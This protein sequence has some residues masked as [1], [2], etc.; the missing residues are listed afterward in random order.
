MT[1]DTIV[2]LE[3]KQGQT[4]VLFEDMQRKVIS[5]GVNEFLDKLCLGHGGTVKGNQK[6]MSVSLN[7]RQKIP[8]LICRKKRFI[9]YPVTQVSG[10][11]VWIRYLYSQKIKK[12]H[13]YKTR[14]I[15]HEQMG[16]DVDA[17][18]RAVQRQHYRCTDYLAQ[19]DTFERKCAVVALT[20]IKLLLK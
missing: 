3:E 18:V 6:A 17:N 9:L 20:D 7:I 11:K 14:L 19:L 5:M 12:V 1:M 16:I 13:E 8:I 15:Y 4:H 2:M 10:T